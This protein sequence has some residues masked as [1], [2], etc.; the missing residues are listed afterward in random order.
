MLVHSPG[1]FDL[2]DPESAVFVAEHLRADPRL[3]RDAK[4]V[5]EVPLVD[6]CLD[7]VGIEVRGHGVLH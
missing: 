5:L 3:E 7:A 1:Q 4:V 2:S 6:E